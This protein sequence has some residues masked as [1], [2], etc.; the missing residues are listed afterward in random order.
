ME[1]AFAGSF[2]VYILQITER[3]I[4]KTFKTFRIRPV[5][6]QL[7]SKF[8]EVLSN[9]SKKSIYKHMVRVKGRS[10]MKQYIKSKPIKWSFKF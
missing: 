4:K 10:R 6:E 7:N 8:F 2:K 9:D 1:T 3:T 5:I